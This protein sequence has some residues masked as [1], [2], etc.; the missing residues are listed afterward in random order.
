ME[1]LRG[2]ARLLFDVIHGLSV[3]EVKTTA[4]LLVYES[5][6]VKLTPAFKLIAGLPTTWASMALALTAM[7]LLEHT[8]P[9]RAS[10]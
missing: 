10:G 7:L 4:G 1:G 9:V 6:H 2:L 5:L 3:H 8:R